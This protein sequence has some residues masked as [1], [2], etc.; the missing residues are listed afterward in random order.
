MA[1]RPDRKITDGADISFFMNETGEKGEVLVFSTAGSGAAMDD[2][3][4]VVTTPTAGSGERLAGILMNDVVNLDLTRQHINWQK[5]EVQLGGKVTVLRHGQITTNVID[6]GAAGTPTAGAPAYVGYGAITAGGTSQGWLSA[7]K[8]TDT[9]EG[10]E[11]YRCGTFLSTKDS[12]G[13]A[14]VEINI[15]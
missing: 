9:G 1:L 8:V 2:A 7:T 13:Y 4:A 12:D 15:L 5:D 11:V 6:T 3:N 10:D 14:K